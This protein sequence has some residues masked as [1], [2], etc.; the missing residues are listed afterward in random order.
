MV[1]VSI[2]PQ[3][4]QVNFGLEIPVIEIP[5]I[6]PCNIRLSGG[7]PG[8]TYPSTTRARPDILSCSTSINY[9]ARILRASSRSGFISDLF[10]LL[11]SFDSSHTHK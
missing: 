4:E 7:W 5:V 11:S 3:P 6:H 9:F 8:P 1:S 2:K 10:S